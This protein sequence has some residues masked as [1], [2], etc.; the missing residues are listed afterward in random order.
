METKGVVQSVNG[1]KIVVLP[2]KSEGCSGCD[3]CHGGEKFGSPM[4]F[5]VDFDIAEGDEVIFSAES[6]DVIKAGL[7]LYVL[8]IFFFFA[9]YFIASK[10]TNIE[11]YKIYSSFGALALSFVVI[12]IFNY[13]IGNKKQSKIEIRKSQD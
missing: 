13:F 7:V 11:L 10:F 2:Y 4:E 12:A 6:S 5:I 1:K 9:G 8:P 3:K